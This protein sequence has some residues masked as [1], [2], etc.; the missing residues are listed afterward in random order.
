[1]S[2]SKKSA[3]LEQPLQMT[4]HWDLIV[5]E[6]S[7][8]LQKCMR[9]MIE[10]CETSSEHILTAAHISAG[11]AQDNFRRSQHFENDFQFG[12]QKFSV[13]QGEKNSLFATEA[14]P[15]IQNLHFIGTD[16]FHDALL[17]AMKYSNSSANNIFTEIQQTY[18]GFG[19]HYHSEPRSKIV[20]PA[21]SHQR[22]SG[23]IPVTQ[24][25]SREEP[26]FREQ[27]YETLLR[28][29][30]LI[31]LSQR[32][33]NGTYSKYIQHG[34]SLS[35]HLEIPES[36]GT[37]GLVTDK[38][39][40]PSDTPTE[41]RDTFKKPWDTMTEPT[42]DPEI[43]F[44]SPSDLA[45]R[46]LDDQ[47]RV[48]HVEGDD[49][50]SPIVF[51]LLNS[52]S[53][54]DVDLKNNI[55]PDASQHL[56]CFNNS[57]LP[58]P[59]LISKA[60]IN[61]I[62]DSVKDPPT[63]IVG[64]PPL[65]LSQFP[66]LSQ[67]NMKSLTSIFEEHLREI[68][69]LDLGVAGL[70]TQRKNLSA[71]CE[72]VYSKLNDDITIALSSFN[73]YLRKIAEAKREVAQFRQLLPSIETANQRTTQSQTVNIQLVE[74]INCISIEYCEVFEDLK[75]QHLRK[76]GLAAT[77]EEGLNSDLGN[78][79]TL[80]VI[81][82][83][84]AMNDEIYHS[85]EIQS[86][87]HTKNL[88][89]LL[90]VC[91]QGSL[92]QRSFLRKIFQQLRR[93][94]RKQRK[95]KDFFFKRGLR[96]SMHLLVMSWKR[97]EVYCGKNMK[98]R[99]ATNWIRRSRVLNWFVK[100]RRI[101]SLSRRR[102][103]YCLQQKRRLLYRGMQVLRTNVIHSHFAEIT[104]KKLYLKLCHF[105]TRR[106]FNSWKSIIQL[107]VCSIRKNHGTRNI[108]PLVVA[109][110][111][112]E[113]Q[114]LRDLEAASQKHLR[115][116][117]YSWKHVVSKS[118]I[119]LTDRAI[120]L[121]SFVSQRQLRS[122][123]RNWLNIYRSQSFHRCKSTTR[124]WQRWARYATRKCR[125]SQSNKTAS[126]SFT[127]R[128]ISCSMRVWVNFRERQRRLRETSSMLTKFM[129]LKILIRSL[130]GWKITYSLRC[131]KKSQEE[132]AMA[133]YLANLRKRSWREWLQA[134]QTKKLS[135]SKKIVKREI[136]SRQDDGRGC[137]E[138]EEEH[139]EEETEDLSLILYNSSNVVL[140]FRAK[141]AIIRYVL[142][143]V[144][145][146]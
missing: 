140:N 109:L 115:T 120:L 1:M 21:V 20:R 24:E 103:E 87:L 67:A 94:T 57:E 72:K 8:H 121:D 112:R 85:A 64:C 125:S 95:L 48:H 5:M 44:A 101:F 42:P 75:R 33:K 61:S 55:L 90:E 114:H 4:A 100:W 7:L 131:K 49:L 12:V 2:S 123:F 99:R 41:P 30:K 107:Q 52:P 137:S 35:P 117:F 88:A 22:T 116:L 91:L 132:N 56:L 113:V 127:L 31:K 142:K 111:K 11:S 129:G 145:P 139:S 144:Y 54:N 138:I 45:E 6:C 102:M 58:L 92:K 78:G 27:K 124:L 50:F 71:G 69:T 70:W 134:C 130:M 122:S 74:R 76:D 106:I 16:L 119:Y 10:K 96:Y 25:P 29:R 18:C 105:Q 62:K 32:P 143:F 135:A 86:N 13:E 83:V 66:N 34:E 28:N 9:L 47:K 15:T 98:N 39:Q 36:I 80:I 93:Q 73:Q 60:L 59:E 17:S 37:Q 26:N 84:S 126:M 77:T 97:L 51:T 108:Q 82:A 118:L 14:I 68:K 89:E 136:K 3:I 104:E 128:R 133:F 79:L 19:L 38:G 110:R 141:R 43:I 40:E 53:L 46:S 23:A 146:H 63:E 81:A 65:P